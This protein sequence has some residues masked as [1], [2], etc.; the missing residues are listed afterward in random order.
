MVFAGLASPGTK[1]Y[2]TALET[3]MLVCAVP[4]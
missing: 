4:R 3:R 1:G 2:H